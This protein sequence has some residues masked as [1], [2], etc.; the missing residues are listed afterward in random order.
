[1]ISIIEEQDKRIAELEKMVEWFKTQFH[2]A[3]HKQ[4]GV[5]SEKTHLNQMTL[6]NA[7]E[8]TAD[9]TQE[10]SKITEVKA[11]YRKRTRLTTDK[12]PED[13]PVEIIEHELPEKDRS[14]P[15][16]GSGM[17]TMGKET[18]EEIKLIP[19]KVVILR[20]VRHIYACRNCEA[21][22]DHVP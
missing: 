22:S 21:T 16:C 10:M 20:H 11:H 7:S 18:R 14:C 8:T 4:Y 1:L 13:L 12:L 3:K 2:L 9:S 5:S 19:A 6:F 15:E 17:H